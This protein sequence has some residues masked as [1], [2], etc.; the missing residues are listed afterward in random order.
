M[1]HTLFLAVILSHSATL[2]IN[3]KVRKGEIVSSSRKQNGLKTFQTQDIA[4]EP[5]VPTSETGQDYAAYVDGSDRLDRVSAP[6]SQAAKAALEEYGKDYSDAYDEE[7]KKRNKHFKPQYLGP[8]PRKTQNKTESG[9]EEHGQDYSFDYYSFGTTAK[10]K[11]KDYMNLDTLPHP[12]DTRKIEKKTI[13][14]KHLP[15]KQ[16]VKKKDQKEPVWDYLVK[17]NTKNGTKAFDYIVD[18]KQ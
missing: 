17:L 14:S 16:K 12:L 2:N 6:G 13:T 1:K 15:D 8:H 5:D 10:S 9:A 7:K 18:V 4:K 11:A 3:A